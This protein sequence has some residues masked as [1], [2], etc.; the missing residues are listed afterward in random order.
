MSD[1][2]LVRA[3]KRFFVKD[4]TRALY[5]VRG[6]EAVSSPALSQT[7]GSHGSGNSSEDTMLRAVVARQPASVIVK[8]GSNQRK[9]GRQPRK[10]K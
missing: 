2:D 8:C 10:D 1:G 5:T 4:Y 7:G 6:A 9:P 3:S